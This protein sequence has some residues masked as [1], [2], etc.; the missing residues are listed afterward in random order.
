MADFTLNAP[1]TVNNPFVPANVLIPVSTLKS[2]ATGFR[3]GTAGTFTPF[4]HNVTYGTTII[5]SATVSA[6]GGN[7]DDWIV[8]G[9][10]RTGANEGA[11]VGLYCVAGG[12]AVLCTITEAGVK[13]NISE[14][15]TVAWTVGDVVVCQLVNNGTIWTITAQRNGTAI[16]FALGNT[17]TTYVSETSM[18][19]GG[20][21]VAGDT[22]GTYFSQFT[23]TGV[24]GNILTAASGTY[25]Y[26]GQSIS[27][28]VSVKLVAASGT[29]A[30]TGQNGGLFPG[31]NSFYLLAAAGAY[32]LI[33][34]TA[35]S[36][37]Q[38]DS[39]AG[40]YGYTGQSAILTQATNIFTLPAA[41]GA[42]AYVGQNV[43]FSSL[44]N[45]VL[46]A[47]PG[48][49]AYFGQAATLSQASPGGAFILPAG[50]GFYAYTGIPATLTVFTPPVTVIVPCTTNFDLISYAY[51]KIGV[52]DENSS[53]TNE[54][55]IVGLS[56]LND[57][58][59]NEAADGMRLGWFTQY[60]L[61]NC[62]PLRPEDV[63]GV[64]ILLA[65]ALA[66]HYGITIQN[67]QLLEAAQTVKTQLVKRSIRY[68]EADFSE[69]SRP[70][71][72]PWGG[73]NWI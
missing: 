35:L 59:L 15:I 18:A 43:T 68:S 31:A 65:M 66:A 36:D 62:C 41:A 69:L 3:A 45:V 11:M 20:E 5:A 10:V 50:F 16:P 61:Q 58:L 63:F 29:Y 40:I 67:P 48:T 42:Y 60:S 44:G 25:T 39:N 49:Y 7:G 54:Q 71:G 56:V 23:G 37:Y 30:Y 26:T 73:P 38:V 53:P 21:F 17:T 72:G 1:G 12:Q 13:T 57:Y 33:G 4:G 47:G 70:Q 55:G 46:T 64:K 14:G 24:S 9:M 27:D 52:I 2:D 8:G 19:A 28:F 51:Q 32:D 34:A 6:I 22:N